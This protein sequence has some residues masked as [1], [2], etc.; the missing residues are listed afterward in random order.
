[1]IARSS[2]RALYPLIKRVNFKKR[3]SLKETYYEAETNVQSHTQ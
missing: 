3:H 1:M 2:L